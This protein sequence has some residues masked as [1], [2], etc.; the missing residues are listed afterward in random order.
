MCGI[1]GIWH[2]DGTPLPPSL[3]LNTVGILTHRGPDDEGYILVPERTRQIIACAG[4]NTNPYLNLPPIERVSDHPFSLGLGFRRLAILDTSPAGHQP[5]VSADGNHVIVFNGEVYNYLELR[6]ELNRYGYAFRTGT[7]TEVILAAYQHWGAQCLSRF[8]GMWALAIWDRQRRRLFLARDPFGIKPLYYINTGSRFAFASEIKALLALPGVSRHVNPQRLYD[9]LRF[10]L[11]DHGDE[12]MFS[13]VAQ[14]PA[15]HYLEVDLERPAVAHATRYWQFEVGTTLDIS[16]DEAAQRLRDLFMDSVR[17]H[18]RSD[19]PV[20]A[21]LSGGIDSSSIVM[22]MRCLEP[23]LDIHTFS[24]T[25][26]DPSVN[27]ERWIDLIGTAARASIHKT[28]PAPKELV[29]DLDYLI[30][31]QDQPF[32][33]TSIYAQHRVF[34]L[35]HE[36]GIK[37]MLDGQGAD[38]LLAGYRS[39]YSARIASLLRR[40]SIVEAARF[41]QT[42]LKQPGSSGREVLL[43]AGGLLLPMKTR[44]HAMRLAGEELLPPWINGDW[45]IAQGVMPKLFWNESSHDMLRRQLHQTLV[46][47]NLPALL[48][49]ED[50]NSMAFSIES[51]V[52]FLTTDLVEFVLSLPEHYLI[53]RDGTTKAVFRK[54][55][56]GIVPDIILDRRDKIGFAT[57]EQRWFSTLQPWIEGVLRSEAAGRIPALNTAAVEQEWQAVLAG[58]R[59][60][61]FRIWRWINLICWA[62]QFDVVF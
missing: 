3:I 11:S 7:D 9:Y 17:L 43:R 1:I 34:K 54:A 16:F 26:D 13:T 49:Y 55:M 33:S 15:A 48:R 18:L 31:I 61:D 27:E 10:G 52:P 12:T 56:R 19:V 20:G 51:R 5:M 62:E 59:R 57:P 21:A 8:V 45:F 47:T 32:G 44:A 28:S 23:D 22:A 46:E 4:Y 53:A 30:Y 39:Y 25:A 6:D 50:R 37:V 58:R 60:F 38:E 14:L 36:A 24:Y 35:A 29:N 2:Q 42:A 41:I 40:G